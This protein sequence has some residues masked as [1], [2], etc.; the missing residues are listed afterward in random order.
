MT[1]FHKYNIEQ[2]KSNTKEYLPYDSI[3]LTYN[4]G[5]T[6]ICS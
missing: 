1:E 5:R 4:T 6:Y 2:K 3:Y